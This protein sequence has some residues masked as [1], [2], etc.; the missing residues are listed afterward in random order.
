MQRQHNLAHFELINCVCVHILRNKVLIALI[1]VSLDIINTYSRNV[2]SLR[3]NPKY[4]NF[5][6]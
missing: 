2:N 6:K 5:S 1:S 4:G 3:L